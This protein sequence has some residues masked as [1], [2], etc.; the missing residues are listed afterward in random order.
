M[1]DPETGWLVCCVHVYLGGM[2]G[3]AQYIVHTIYEHVE[4]DKSVVCIFISSVP[5]SRNQ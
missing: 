2:D 4:E 3:R 5:R 1:S